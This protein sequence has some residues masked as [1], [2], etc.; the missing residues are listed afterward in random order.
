MSHGWSRDVRVLETL[1][2]VAV[3]PVGPRAWWMAQTPWSLSLGRAGEVAVI[4]TR[5]N[6]V[7]GRVPCGQL[8]WGV[9][10]ATVP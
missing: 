8:P 1:A 5:T 9:A 3:I 2:V 4:D 6:A 10:I 7:V